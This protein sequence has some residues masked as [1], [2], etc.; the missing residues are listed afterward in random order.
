MAAQLRLRSV[1]T[2]NTSRSVIR[3]QAAGAFSRNGPSPSKA[4]DVDDVLFDGTDRYR[5][6]CGRRSGPLHR[7]F[8]D[9]PYR[10]ATAFD[11]ARKI[12]MRRIS[13]PCKRAGHSSSSTTTGRRSE[14]GYRAMCDIV[15]DDAA[16]TGRDRRARLHEVAAHRCVDL[17]RR[18]VGDEKS[19]P[20]RHGRQRPRG[21]SFSS[22]STSVSGAALEPQS[23]MTESPGH[24]RIDRF[25]KDSVC[26]S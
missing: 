26:S 24:A 23:R 5:R 4:C 14:P 11:S 7:I 2:G 19:P 9:T 15:G 1:T 22:A 16:D 10:L 12:E 18:P 6:P 25:T 13:K 3:L 17:T 20:R 8:T 21:M